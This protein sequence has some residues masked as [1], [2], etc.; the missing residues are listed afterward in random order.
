MLFFLSLLLGKRILSCLMWSAEVLITRN[1]V[2]RDSACLPSCLLSRSCYRQGHSF[3]DILGLTRNFDVKSLMCFFTEFHL[4]NLVNN[5]LLYI[6]LKQERVKRFVTFCCVVIKLI[7]SCIFSIDHF[8]YRV[9]HQNIMWIHSY[10]IIARISATNYHSM[11]T[12]GKKGTLH[13]R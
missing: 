4:R 2:R 9:T 3:H 8:I 5:G 10:E 7:Y 6:I 11:E 12:T 1:S 13:C